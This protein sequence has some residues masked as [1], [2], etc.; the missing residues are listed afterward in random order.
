MLALPEQTCAHAHA[1]YAKICKP[2]HAATQTGNQ[3]QKSELFVVFFGE[4]QLEHDHLLAQAP[5]ALMSM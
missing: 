2:Q 1:K 4:K 3:S 5:G